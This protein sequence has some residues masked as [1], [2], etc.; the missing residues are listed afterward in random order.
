MGGRA[1]AAFKLEHEAARRKAVL[2]GGLTA[3]V[4]TAA[5][6]LGLP[7]V[8][9]KFAAL[10]AS[11][12][13]AD[14]WR[15]AGDVDV[16]VASARSHALAEALGTVGL[17]DAGFPGEAHQLPQLRDADG[18]A[19]EVHV[20]LPG[21]R[22]R[23]GGPMATA[24]ALAAAG[25]L[26]RLDL[27]GECSLPLLHVMAAHALVHGLAQ[28]GFAPGGY[29]AFRL[30]G[31]LIA[32]GAHEDGG[33]I[34]TA[35]LPFV[36]DEVAPDEMAAAVALA[37]RLARGD[38]ALF[39]EAGTPEAVLLRHF[40]AGILD[41]DYRRSLRLHGLAGE[42]GGLVG[43]VRAARNALVLTDAQID[44]VYG[45]P[46]WRLGY[47]GRRLVRPF[48]L[49]WRAARYAAAGARVRRRRRC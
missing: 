16:L 40:V 29:P 12:R 30:V 25:L 41:G 44:V 4:A 39:E 10:R 34:A 14:G 37:A 5:A 27:P 19:V 23:P 38:A 42:R 13:V 6:G 21:L 18:R 35:A 45:P 31:D 3:D 46:R 9:L 24:D 49:A 22:L 47:L 11:G 26:Q 7:I 8:L 32:L 36:A 2:L 33:P 43:L 17:R 15:G 20:H 48:D 28:H 1:A